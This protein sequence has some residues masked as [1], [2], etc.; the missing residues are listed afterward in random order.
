MSFEALTLDR[1]NVYVFGEV[2]VRSKAIG[3]YCYTL[4]ASSASEFKLLFAVRD[5]PFLFNNF[6]FKFSWVF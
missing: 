4:I 3:A 2:F 6:D 5:E 1:K